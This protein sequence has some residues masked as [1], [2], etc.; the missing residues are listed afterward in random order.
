MATQWFEAGSVVGVP[1]PAQKWLG[2]DYDGDE[3]NVLLESRNPELTRQIN[4]E[5]QEEQVNPKLPKSF[6]DNPR[7][8]RDDRLT[9]MRSP[10][11]T[12]WSS[13]A[14]KLRSLD[15]DSQYVL[16]EK[17]REGNI[18]SDE[19]LGALE[20]EDAMWLEVGKGIK[21]GTDG[22]KTSVPVEKYELRARAYQAALT[23]INL[24][25]LPYTKA[26][27]TTIEK[28][29]APSLTN[30]YWRNAYFA[31]CNRIDTGHAAPLWGVPAATL[32]YMLWNLFP[33]EDRRLSET[34]YKTW[35]RDERGYT[36]DLY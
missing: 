3:V 30:A 22:Y 15:P 17:L 19:E 6:T 28:S 16:A 8:S 32:A 2:G 9:A 31:C 11:V 4:D 33:E 35:L 7:G 1:S 21:V 27:M 13:I 18:L 34:H 14:A 12:A 5:Y 10:N 24:Y 23:E 26:L 36:D 20:V 25:P 29:G